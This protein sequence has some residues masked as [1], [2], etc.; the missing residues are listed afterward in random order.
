MLAGLP[1][2]KSHLVN[3]FTLVGNIKDKCR[4]NKNNNE[5]ISDPHLNRSIAILI[6]AILKTYS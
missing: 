4:K 6:I 1:L 3:Y 5:N 2:T